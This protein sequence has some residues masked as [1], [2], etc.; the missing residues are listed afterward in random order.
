MKKED[1]KISFAIKIPSSNIWIPPNGRPYWTHHNRS[2]NAGPHL[3]DEELKKNG[4]SQY[5]KYK[6]NKGW[7]I[8][9]KLGNYE[10]LTICEDIYI[11]WTSRK[12]IK[13]TL[14]KIFT[15]WEKTIP[16]WVRENSK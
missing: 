5:K 9:V 10:K 3:T 2:G 4:L 12:S 14:K 13:W 16:K 6:Y 8:S 1:T 7:A 15:K 11:K